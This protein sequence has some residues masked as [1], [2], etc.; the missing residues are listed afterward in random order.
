MFIQNQYLNLE[1][2]VNFIIVVATHFDFTHLL[3][4]HHRE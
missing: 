1:L 4:I 2:F 3:I